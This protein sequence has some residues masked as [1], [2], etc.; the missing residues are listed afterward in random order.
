MPFP[1]H[2]RERDNFSQ[3]RPG[4]SVALRARR[5]RAPTPVQNV[6]E[7]LHPLQTPNAAQ[8]SSPRLRP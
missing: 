8:P 5:Q 7:P 1:P 3:M 2:R 4:V 6:N